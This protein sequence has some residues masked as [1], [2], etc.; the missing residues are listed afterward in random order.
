MGKRKADT[1]PVLELVPETT[2]SIRSQDIPSSPTDNCELD[3]Q[4]HMD[5]R[6]TIELQPFWQLL[7][8]AGYEIW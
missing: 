5:N 4:G 7:S 2:P 3:P 1:P 8:D 6:E